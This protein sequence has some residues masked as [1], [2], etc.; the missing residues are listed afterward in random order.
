[1]K[2]LIFIILLIHT[3]NISA[4]EK[5]GFI[6]LNNDINDV[7]VEEAIPVVNPDTGFTAVFLKVKKTFI[8]YLLNDTQDV[9]KTLKIESVPRNYDVLVGSVYSNQKFG[10]YFSNDF[11]SKHACLQVDF[12][13][14]DFTFVEDLELDFKK[15]RFISYIENKDQFYALSIVKNSSIL[16]LNRLDME[17]KI[18]L[19]S[20]DVSKEDFETDNGL[21]LKLDS[22]L[23]GKHSDGT[24]EAINTSIPNTIETTSASTKVYINDNVITLTNN[25]FKKFIY[26][27]KLNLDAGTAKLSKIE[28]KK[29]DK[30]N[31]RSNSNSFVL[32]TLFF[33]TYSDTE[34]MSL[35]IFDLE[36]EK[37]IK[38][39]LIKAGDSISF[40]NS[41]FIHEVVNTN[42]YRDLEK[43]SRFIRKVNSSNIG[44][45]VYPYH[46]NYILTLGSSEKIQTG[47]FAIIGGILG[48]MIGAAIF[49]AF[50]SYNKTQ[51]T[52]IECLFDKQFNH[53]EGEIPENGFDKI[54]N[55]ID[56]N[57]LE[58]AKLQ[59]V[60]KYRD[61]YIWGFYNS[62][63]KFYGFHQFSIQ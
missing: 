43:T 14:D 51:S 60:F 1:M 31:L 47:E 61:S 16:N 13:S 45:S 3:F 42:S 37:M 19:T 5:W 26:I 52:R 49:S 38:S 50:D 7:K 44:I 53:V 62:D 4:Q 54:Q 39:F 29:F 24:V 27:I 55:Y 18:T 34:E 6:P 22:L 36:N 21:P 10:L 58:R 17:G 12:E 59:T 41:P 56:V 40:K 30:K 63:G 23:F 20:F 32:N 35:N 11:K 33:D 28:N 9:I 15:E 8:C 25:T 46:D 57:S 2:N 48:G